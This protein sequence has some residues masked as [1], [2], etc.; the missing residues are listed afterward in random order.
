MGS[1]LQTKKKYLVQK[2]I[3]GE[4]LQGPPDY[5]LQG[6]NEVIR[7]KNWVRQTITK[8]TKKSIL[9]L[10]GHV[11]C[12][13][14]NRLPKRIMSWSPGERRRRGRLEVEWDK[15]VERVMKQRDLACDAGTVATENR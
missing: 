4:E 14:D 2:W 7:E 5:L 12:M 9:K 6:R 1:R 13:E 3:I 10:T 15:E 11:V 8:R